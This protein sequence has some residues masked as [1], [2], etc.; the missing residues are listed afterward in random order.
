MKTCIYLMAWLLCH[1]TTLSAQPHSTQLDYLQNHKDIAVREMLRTG[2]PA[3][4]I[5]AQALLESGAGHN[6]LA[7]SANNHFG[8]QCGK[9]WTGSTFSQLTYNADGELEPGCFRVY[10]NAAA[11]FRDHSNLIIAPDKIQRYRMLFQL[12]TTDYYGWANG[13]QLT[14]FS[15]GGAY[16]EKLIRTIED[17]GLYRYDAI[18]YMKG[19]LPARYWTTDVVETTAMN[20]ALSTNEPNDETVFHSQIPSVERMNAQPRSEFGYQYRDPSTGT[21]DHQLAYSEQKTNEHYGIRHDQTANRSGALTADH[22]S[23]NRYT[24]YPGKID[25]GFDNDQ[26][27]PSGQS[28]AVVLAAYLPADHGAGVNARPQP[29]LV[30]K[31]YHKVSR[32]ETLSTIARQYRTTVQKLIYLNA[33]GN[34]PVQSGMI[35]QVS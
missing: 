21:Y 20:D 26:F 23:G 13:L 32:R 24:P 29:T 25:S 33:L 6:E 12:A 35:L 15:N 31:V 10:P 30:R 8:I 4:I 27:A 18:F 16:A 9:S 17:Y 1:V 11:S 28:P 14:G 5:L 7:L 34:G 3:S 22:S 19:S 2:I